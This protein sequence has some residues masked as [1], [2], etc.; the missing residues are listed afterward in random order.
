MSKALSSGQAKDYYQKEYTS[1]KENYYSERGE[2][3]G[4]WS[5]RL[6]EEWN[7]QGEVQ[8]EQYERLVAGQHPHTGEQLIRAARSKE[9]VNKYGEEITVN[10][11]RAAW[12]AT[13][14]APKSVSVAALVGNDERI[15]SAHRESVNEAL[16]E[17]EQYMQARGGGNKP[18]ITTGK[19]VAA[20]FEHTAARPDHRTGYAAPQLHTH[21]VIFNMTETADEKIRSVQPLELYRSQQYATAIYRMNLAEKLQGLGYEIE[22]DARTGAPEIKGFSKEYLQGSSPRREEVRKEAEE[23]KARLESEGITVKEGAGLNQ[24]AARTDRASKQY[25]HAEMRER[26]LE[27]DAR[28]DNQAERC[29]ERALENGSLIRSADEIAKRAQEAVSFA[30]D[31]AMEREAV[32]EIRKVKVDALRRNM[33]LTTYQAVVSELAVRQRQGEF[34]GI[35][36]DQQSPETTTRNM[37]EMEQSNIRLMLDGRGQYPPIIGRERVNVAIERVASGKEIEL[38]DNQLAAVEQLLTSRDQIIGLQGGAGTGKTTALTALR[39]AAES[40]GYEVRGFAPTTRAAQQLSESGIQTETLQKFLRRR[41]EAPN[42]H[43]RLFVLDESSLAST[44]NVHTFFARLE[45]QDKVLLVGDIKQ[46]QA[47]EAGSPFAQFQ[48][49]GM[50][51]AKLNKIVRQRD[52]RLRQVVKKLSASQVKEAID[53][54]QK[55]GRIVEIA[56]DE[57]R[58]LAIADAYCKSPEN[59]LVISPANKERGLLNALIHRHLQ[60]DGKVSRADHQMTIYVNRQDMTGTERTF[61]NAYVADE[62]IVRYSRVSNVYGFKVGDYARVTATNHE[63]NEITVETNDGRAV[64]YNPT[65]LSG[66]NVYQERER[67]FSEGDRIQFRAPFAE[68]KVANGELGTIRQI[69]DDEFTVAMDSGREIAFDTERFRHIDHG[70]AVTSYSSQ[71][72]TVDRVLVNADANESDLLLNQ[73]MGYVAISRAREEA[74]I[75]TNSTERLR[76]ALDRSVDKEMAIEALRQSRDQ[77]FLSREESDHFLSSTNESIADQSFGQDSSREEGTENEQPGEE[78]ELDLGS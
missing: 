1:A 52:A 73:R 61:A 3:N 17:L 57:R 13:F 55:Q 72:Q 50:E 47:V 2:V 78:M 6:A 41:E 35:V 77:N 21:V 63:R 66:V 23:M 5:G 33:G 64:T 54:L 9:Q 28:Y 22:I 60:H 46:H 75:F 39:Q 27:M 43:N 25:D 71:A 51:T 42:S 76:D 45:A 30:R 14:S 4:Q 70:Y 11:H 24:A 16:K 69:K 65:R 15:R 49:H 74:L 34:I 7:L 29:V 56:A 8:S 37:L 32:V 36:R 58:L 44:K 53:N 40:E 19:M 26:A 31:N 10:E 68:H 12:D 20:Q 62:D 38:N 59:S 18:A 48:K 67:S